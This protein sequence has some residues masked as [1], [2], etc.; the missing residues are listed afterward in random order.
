[1][2]QSVDEQVRAFYCDQE[3]PEAALNRLVERTG[4]LRR[5]R[6]RRWLAVAAAVL[7]AVAGGFWMRHVT[8]TAGLAD[9][10]VAEVAT[11]HRK[12]LAVEVST[13]D[14]Q[15]LGQALDKLPF[16][17]TAPE[18]ARAQGYQLVGGRYCTIQAQIAAQLKIRHPRTG[19]LATLYITELSPELAALPGQR[20]TA[21]EITVELWSQD[22]LLYALAHADS[23]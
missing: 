8:A 6:R 7:L 17:V 23:S 1:M 18:A 21:D 3:M 15:Q 14:Y 4:E 16:A 5:A 19:R 10:V 20:R 22:G 11:N 9:R 13:F 12:D 2:R